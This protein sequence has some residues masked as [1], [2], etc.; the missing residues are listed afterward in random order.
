MN[1]ELINYEQL[2]KDYLKTLTGDKLTEAEQTQ[3]I[4]LA[5]AYNLNPFKRQ[6]YAVKFS[7][8]LTITVSYQVILSVATRHP[9]FGGIEVQ[10]Y[11]ENNP[12]EY[13][14]SLTPKLWAKVRIYKY[15][16]TSRVLHN[17]TRINFSEDY[18]TQRKN[19]FAQ[20]Y[21]TAWC[22]KL[23]HVAIV[24]KT[25]PEETDG[26][27]TKDE[28]KEEVEEVEEVKPTIQ[29]TINNRN[30]AIELVEKFIENDED[31]KVVIST[32]LKK[33]KTK[34]KDWQAGNINLDLLRN[35]IEDQL[36]KQE[37]VEKEV[38]Q[39][40]TDIQSI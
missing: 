3:F 15:I 21:F 39:K 30:E 27:Y 31:K 2:A 29:P 32:Y 35:V 16:G 14:D 28:F 33:S 25:Y 23:A 8:K 20:D 4:M 13:F 6:V 11:S 19:K 9:D 40:E 22:E 17:E 10:Y 36:N 37:K 1:N 38:C 26:M 12:I 7:G 5:K 18:Q 24:R 34:L